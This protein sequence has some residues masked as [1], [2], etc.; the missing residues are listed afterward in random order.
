VAVI[1]IETKSPTLD[2]AQLDATAAAIRKLYRNAEELQIDSR[3]VAVG[4]RV[5]SRAAARAR[6]RS[7]SAC[8]SPR[9]RRGVSTIDG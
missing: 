4:A 2:D 6:D 1:R 8:R 9:W 5:L 7:R 3:C